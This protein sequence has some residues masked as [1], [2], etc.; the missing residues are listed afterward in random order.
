MKIESIC[1]K[2]NSNTGGVDA[3]KAYES[4]IAIKDRNGGNLTR[5]AI[6]AKAKA[7]SHLLHPIFEWDDTEAAKQHRLTQAGTL[8]R[9]IEVTYK[10]L[11][12]RPMRAFEITERK[13]RGNAESKTVYKTNDE[14]MSDP[15]ARDALI[16]EA[17]RAAMAFRRRFSNL[18]E[19][20][21][22]FE[23]IDKVAEELVS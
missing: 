19:L 5:E 2:A 11:P 7:K 20:Q 1:W 23:A 12:K 6:V 21:L 8:I 17:I 3:E 9:S 16:A 10:E 13:E 22:I 18:R 14:A 15:V 4:L